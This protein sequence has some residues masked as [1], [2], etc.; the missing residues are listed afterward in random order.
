VDLV[1]QVNQTDVKATADAAPA[2]VTV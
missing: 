1:E 2:D